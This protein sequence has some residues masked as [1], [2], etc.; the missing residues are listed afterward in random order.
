MSGDVVLI[1]QMWHTECSSCGYGRGG[2]P[3]S[4]AREGKEILGPES[5]VCHGCGERFTHA[6]YPY[7]GR[8][9]ALGAEEEAA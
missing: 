6:E 5:R 3:S 7:E 9:F 2:W 1:V 4:P 8:F